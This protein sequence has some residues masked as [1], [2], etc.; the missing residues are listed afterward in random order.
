MGCLKALVQDLRGVVHRESDP[1]KICHGVGDLLRYYSEL[2][3]EIPAHLRQGGDGCYARHLIHRDGPDGFC[4][5]AMVWGPGQ[6]T[7]IHDHGGT[8][9]VEGCIEGRLEITSYRCQALDDQRLRFQPESTLAVGQG[10]VGCLIPPFEHHRV[11]NPYSENAL[12]IHVYGQELKKC[13]RFHHEREDVYRCESVQL[14]YS[15]RPE[16]DSLYF[17]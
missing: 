16:S 6:G 13:R 14:C 2:P 9:C 3:I 7:P 10:S 4:V 5:V 11:H 17:K 15:S 8:W 1:E 12:T